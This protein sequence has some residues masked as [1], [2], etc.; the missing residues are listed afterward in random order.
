MSY[1]ILID[2]HLGSS[3]T[4]LTLEAQ[5]I[6][7]ATGANVGAAITSGFVEIGNGDYQW[8]KADMSDGQFGIKFQ[9][10]G[11][12]AHKAFVTVG[13]EQ[14]EHDATQALIAAIPAPGPGAVEVVEVV[15]EVVVV[16]G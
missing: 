12:G 8:Y 5:I 2:I 6:D 1:P 13:T 16:E 9:V 3:Q 10:A 7:K 11:G 14:A 15:E 4:G